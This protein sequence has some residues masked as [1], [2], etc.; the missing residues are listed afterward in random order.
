MQ[1]RHY[2]DLGKKANLIVD[3][4]EYENEHTGLFTTKS[5]ILRIIQLAKLRGIT[6]EEQFKKHEHTQLVDIKVL[7]QFSHD[8]DQYKKDY[9]LIDFTDMITEFVKMDRSPR[10]DVVFIDEAQD[11]SRSQWQMARS[12][13]DKTQDTYIAGDDD[14]AIFKW[15]G[16]DVDSFIAQKGKVMQLTQSYRIPQVVHDIASKIVNKIQHRLPKE[17]KPKTQRGLLSYYDEFK[18]VNM[19]QGNWL[20]L[21]RTK[22]MLTDVEEALYEQGLYYQNK[23]KTNKEQDLYKAVTD[24]ENVRKGV[25]INYDQIVRI[26]S[27]MSQNHFEKQALKYIDKEGMYGIPELRERRWLKTDK[28]W[29]EAFDQAPSR[30]IRYIRRMRENGEKLNSSPRI[31][32]STIHGVKGGEQDNVVLLTD[33]SRNT[34]INYEKNPDDENRLFYVGATRTKTHLHIIRPKDNYKGYKI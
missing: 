7:K 31:V 25:N 14:Q 5:D 11:L 29:Y 17:W 6:P 32:L 33:L 18:Q 27:Y 28:I 22:F 34:Q 30:S 1:R 8:L 24:W 16:A 20:V 10:F 23:F 26:A 13:W 4:H 2:E 3:Y 12:I 19:K 21:A 9:N 15:A